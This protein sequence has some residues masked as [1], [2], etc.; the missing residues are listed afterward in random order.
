[1]RLLKGNELEYELPVHKTDVTLMIK[2][3]PEGSIL[4]EGTLKWWEIGENESHRETFIISGVDGCGNKEIFRLYLNIFDCGRC[5][6]GECQ[7]MEHSE[8]NGDDN[9]SLVCKCQ[10]GYK[11]GSHYTTLSD[12]SMHLYF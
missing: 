2:S 5:D 8:D 4:S 6:N 12:W 10:P 1:M 3:A 9:D 7:V 11:G